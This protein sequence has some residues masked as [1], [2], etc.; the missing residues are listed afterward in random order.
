[1]QYRHLLV[2]L[3]LVTVSCHKE[4]DRDVAT[5]EQL[6]EL[7]DSYM[8][9]ARTTN[10]EYRAA[11]IKTLNDPLLALDNSCYDWNETCIERMLGDN[12]EQVK[13]M[14]Y[15]TG[16]CE[17]YVRGHP[18]YPQDERWCD[19]FIREKQLKDY[20]KVAILYSQYQLRNDY[21]DMIESDF[22]DDIQDDFNRLQIMDISTLLLQSVGSGVYWSWMGY[23]K[24]LIVPGLANNTD[25]DHESFRLVMFNAIESLESITHECIT[26]TDI[27]IEK[28]DQ[29]LSLRIIESYRRR[30]LARQDGTSQVLDGIY[31]WHALAIERA[32]HQVM[33]HE[34]NQSMVPQITEEGYSVEDLIAAQ[35][36]IMSVGAMQQATLT[37]LQDYR[38]NQTCSLFARY[39][40][41]EEDNVTIEYPYL[42][43]NSKLECGLNLTQY[44]HL[45]WQDYLTERGDSD[46]SGDSK[47]FFDWEIR[48]YKFVM[49]RYSEPYSNISAPRY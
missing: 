7:Y 49:C 12:Y 9:Q 27:P 8:L 29:A 3:L 28:T 43:L 1:M 31:Q 38:K 4:P 39:S 19:A 44:E 21:L 42:F 48:F 13:N 17:E 36:I 14:S 11:L 6:Q 20:A 18:Y 23:D 22:S 46:L 2:M 33:R 41:T 26:K 16:K 35:S 34:I 40:L 47:N 10:E 15:D 30:V 24:S 37:Y 25:D 5:P 45:R 32:V